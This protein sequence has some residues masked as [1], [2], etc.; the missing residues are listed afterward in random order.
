MPKSVT[1]RNVGVSQTRLA[2]KDPKA[3]RRRDHGSTIISINKWHGSLIRLLSHLLA[4]QIDGLHNMIQ[5][6]AVM[7]LRERLP[8]DIS[9]ARVEIHLRSSDPQCPISRP[10]LPEGPQSNY[11]GSGEVLLEEDLRVRRSTDRLNKTSVLCCLSRETQGKT[12]K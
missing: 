11:D 5:S 9:S 7:L 12:Y 10:Q 3:W 8:I 2:T 1:A 4:E 6:L